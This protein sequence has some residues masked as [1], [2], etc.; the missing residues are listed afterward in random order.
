MAVLAW[1]APANLLSSSSFVLLPVPPFLNLSSTMGT[2][3]S[4]FFYEDSEEPESLE[5][6]SQLPSRVGLPPPSST[7]SLGASSSSAAPRR[8]SRNS[9]AKRPPPSASRAV[10][11]RGHIL[12]LPESG[13]RTLVARLRGRDPFRPTT[14]HN[15]APILEGVE[16]A[17]PYQAPP[18][19]PSWGERIQLGVY[20]ADEWA[21]QTSE[22]LDFAV[23]LVN[24][25]HKRKK[26]KRY[27]VKRLQELLHIMGY[28]SQGD[29]PR[30]LPLR[31]LC[32]CLLLNFRD[33]NAKKTHVEQS[34]LT[35]WTMEVLQ[36]CPGLDP[37]KLV[38]QCGETSL[39]NCYGLGLLHHFIYRSYLQRRQHQLEVDLLQV[40]VAQQQTK[41]P[42]V[43]SYDDFL[44]VL[45]G[46]APRSS[47]RKERSNETEKSGR[48]RKIV[49][50]NLSTDASAKEA[51]VTVNPLPAKPPKDA[52]EA[53]LASSDEE[54]ETNKVPAVGK[55][56]T[57]VP[58]DDDSD[59][60]DDFV[61]EVEGRV[62]PER[63]ERKEE[64]VDSA[65]TYPPSSSKGRL[66]NT[67]KARSPVST[68]DSSVASASSPP[69][70]A[71]EHDANEEETAYEEASV[72]PGGT[73]RKKA[74]KE[75]SDKEKEK[76]A[77]CKPQA[78]IEVARKAS[79][80]VVTE[81]SPTT[82]P[83]SGV[84][85][86]DIA[87][88]DPAQGP[89]S[90][91]S[92]ED[93]EMVA[94]GSSVSKLTGDSKE[95]P[96]VTDAADTHDEDDSNG[97]DAVENDIGIHDDDESSKDEAPP[98]SLIASQVGSID[99]DDEESTSSKSE[100]SDTRKNIAPSRS[101]PEEDSDDDEAFF[102]DESPSAKTA[103][104]PPPTTSESKREDGSCADSDRIE[105][106]G[107]PSSPATPM[108]REDT[109]E[110]DKLEENA[111]GEAAEVVVLSPSKSHDD[112]IE[113][114]DDDDEFFVGESSA[115]DAKPSPVAP[116]TPVKATTS[117]TAAN[118]KAPA[119]SS[120]LSAAA[121]AAIAAAQRDFE[122]MMTEQQHQ[123][124]PG[125]SFP[126]KKKKKSKKKK[127]KKVASLAS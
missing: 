94:E 54:E 113:E 77:T 43:Q 20:A 79:A 22:P 103:P 18:D 3:E 85:A 115:E 84:D 2:T 81:D 34:N 97:D 88:E 116:K 104:D 11:L 57:K 24:P 106:N 119:A 47:S 10:K 4:A 102:V 53:F 69:V 36:E 48:R 13:K 26:V 7:A 38:L 27:L 70:D 21:Q 1:L 35:M 63:T 30:T 122:S 86:T 66:A 59:D 39:L 51:P 118:A 76:S 120:G 99:N 46:K 5:D 67:N 107:G 105:V 108:S 114:E 110:G 68:A 83:E 75:A 89:S 15:E 58:A 112:D 32:L 127:D 101:T 16:H 111:P 55:K 82:E 64:V 41:L 80:E 96:S 71:D 45:D 95:N 93:G 31:P 17:L 73:M 29:G 8:T 28:F 90:P 9:A 33:V 74:K 6:P 126:K 62:S 49:A 61:V 87:E 72:E 78:T 65:T 109:H 123:E 124:D 25:L 12:G 23:V 42:P 91:S 125:D 44:A 37:R 40:H 50:H 98:S 92:V 19:Q 100:L 14:D 121:R 60:D 117:P 52:L 56:K